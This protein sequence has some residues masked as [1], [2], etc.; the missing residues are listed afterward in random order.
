M[1][2]ADIGAFNTLLHN[3]ASTIGTARKVVVT[4]DDLAKRLL[5]Q[6]LDRVSRSWLTV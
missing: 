2:I 1:A 6:W 4:Y 3:A 5:A